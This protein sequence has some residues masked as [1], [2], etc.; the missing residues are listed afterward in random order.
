[1]KCRDYEGVVEP[2]KVRLAISRAKYLGLRGEDLKDALQRV[3]LELSSFRYDPAKA[4]GADE[5][6]AVL[7][8]LDRRLIQIQRSFL[9]H[10]RRYE[11]ARLD[12]RPAP[13]G[14]DPGL[15]LDVREALGKL[16]VE[17]RAICEGLVKGLNLQEIAALLGLSWHTTK[18]LAQGIRALFESRG[19]HE[20]LGPQ[21]LRNRP[22]SRRSSG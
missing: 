8:L 15:C 14:A 13:G 12:E 9:R 22:A 1:M 17:E 16:S 18:R 7:G 19:L 6:S 21:R 3:M 20:Y 2:W 11:T 4:N 10:Q 5:Q